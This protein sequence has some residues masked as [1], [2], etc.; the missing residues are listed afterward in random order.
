MFCVRTAK[1]MMSLRGCA[2]SPKLWLVAK[3]LSNV[4]AEIYHAGQTTGTSKQS[5]SK[6]Y[7]IVMSPHWTDLSVVYQTKPAKLNFLICPAKGRS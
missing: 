2:T 3:P 7:I 4:L 1:A 6:D 5:E